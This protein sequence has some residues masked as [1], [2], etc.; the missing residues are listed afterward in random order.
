MQTGQRA[1]EYLRPLPLSMTPVYVSGQLDG[2]ELSQAIVADMAWQRADYARVV[3]TLVDCRQPIVSNPVLAGSYPIHLRRSHT[4]NGIVSNA[5]YFELLKEAR[6][7]ETA[8]L[9]R[10]SLIGAFVMGRMTI[11]YADDLMWPP[12]PEARGIRS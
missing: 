6:V 9:I 8:K 12:E 4:T 11:D 5:K 2:G 3:T 7:L 1:V 10:I